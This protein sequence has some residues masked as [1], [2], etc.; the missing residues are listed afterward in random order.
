[1]ADSC[2]LNVSSR[3]GLV[4]SVFGLQG[5]CIKRWQLFFLII[6]ALPDK[7]DERLLQACIRAVGSYSFCICIASHAAWVVY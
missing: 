3:L 4:L 5:R 6:E 7:S 2:K 1:M